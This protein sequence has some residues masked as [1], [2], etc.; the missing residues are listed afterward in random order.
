MAGT[1]V[2]IDGHDGSG[3]SS[4]GAAVA[5]RHS[6]RFV[7]PFADSLGDYIASLWQNKRFALASDVARTAVERVLASAGAEGVVCDRHWTTMFTVLPEVFWHDW[8][9]DGLP[10]TIVCWASTPVTM[11]R[12][13]ERGED[14]GEPAKHEHY[15]RLYRELASRAPRSFLLDTTDLSLA[16]AVAETSATLGAWLR[17]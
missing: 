4:I 10:P 8:E 11:R 13:R 9:S 12:L 16:D 14:P 2:A 7:R 5:E 3:K 17:G 1:I 6:L 15:H